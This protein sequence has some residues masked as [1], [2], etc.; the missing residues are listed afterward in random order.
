MG[1]YSKDQVN[2]YLKQLE[3]VDTPYRF[4]LLLDEFKEKALSNEIEMWFVFKNL[5]NEAIANAKIWDEK[6][7]LMVGIIYILIDI[8]NEKAYA[9]LKWYVQNFTEETPNGVIELLA[10]LIP[11][12][13]FVKFNEYHTYASSEKK[14]LSA[15][16]FLILFNL[17]L[18]RR[19]SSEEETILYKLSKVFRNDRYYFGNVNEM[20]Q[21]RFKSDELDENSERIDLNFAMSEL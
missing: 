19:L 13:K 5:I 6:P 9:L 2:E 7:N 18:E 10:S 12:F 15:L 3:Q 16:G 11:T 20:I 14:A 21:S 4:Q 8:G 1:N 17:M